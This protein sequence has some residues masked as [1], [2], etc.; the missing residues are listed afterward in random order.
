MRVVMFA[1]HMPDQCGAFFHDV[2][3]AKHLIAHG[4]QVMFVFMKRVS[5]RGLTGVYRGIPYKY[6]MMAESDLQSAD[7]WT[8]P[9]YPIV[10][11]VRKLNERFQKPIV[12]TA[13]F[14]ENIEGLNPYQQSGKWAEA[15]F[16]VSHYM[17]RTVEE[18][19]QLSPTIRRTDVLYPIVKE[20]EIAL[21]DT[22][23][24]GTYITLVNGNLLKGV[25][26]F[27]RVADRMKEHAFLGIRAYYRHVQVHN[28]Q[29]VTWENYSDDIRP[30]LAKTRILMVPVSTYIVQPN[31]A[32]V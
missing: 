8:T 14:A 16:Y 3:A 24:P 7:V 10:M 15:L 30:V 25:D 6:Y 18:R 17:K 22:R 13:H 27:L 23:E 12:I 1:V 31:I 29:N 9:H 5:T 28:T 26:V 20:H 2:V 19:I 21:P 11:S 32:V 4:H